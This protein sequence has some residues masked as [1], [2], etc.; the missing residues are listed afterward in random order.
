MVRRPRTTAHSLSRSMT[1]CLL[2]STVPRRRSDP[3]HCSYG[4]RAVYLRRHVLTSSSQY[5]YDGLEDAAHVLSIV[6]LGKDSGVFLDVDYVAVS[7]YIKATPPTTTVSPSA[8]TTASTT[9]AAA[10]LSAASRVPGAI[11]GALAGLLLVGLVLWALLVWMPRRARARVSAQVLD[12]RESQL[13]PPTVFA[14]QPSRQPSSRSE[15]VCRPARSPYELSP[16]QIRLPG[17]GAAR[18]RECGRRHALPRGPVTRNEAG[19]A[20]VYTMSNL[21]SSNGL[22]L[23]LCAC[24]D[25]LAPPLSRNMHGIY[26]RPHQLHYT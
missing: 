3:K 22:P 24:A 5:S 23:C 8:S 17:T 9:P 13:G 4:W 26:L 7:S 12:V 19:C 14:P 11:A 16:A 1:A 15:C 21:A 10:T 25:R 6:N 20:A 2:S 18:V